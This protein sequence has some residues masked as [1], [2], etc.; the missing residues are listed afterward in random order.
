[1][2]SPTTV[3]LCGPTCSGK[4]SVAKVLETSHRFR[5]IIPYTTRPLRVGEEHGTEY[6]HVTDTTFWE[7]R[8]QHKFAE[9]TTYSTTQGNWAY[10]TMISDYEGDDNKV[11]VLNPITIFRLSR[12]VF[13]AMHVVFLDVGKATCFNRARARGDYVPEVMRRIES[14]A[15]IF[16]RVRQRNG[17]NVTYSEDLAVEEIATII[18]CGVKF[19]A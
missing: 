14:D 12:R 3:I 8:K 18:A 16:A 17:F 19:L 4:S 9:V 13:S 5:R 1:M 15:G 2:K 7:L 10:G 6:F 11:V